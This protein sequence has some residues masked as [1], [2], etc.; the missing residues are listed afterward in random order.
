MQRGLSVRA[1]GVDDVRIRIHEFLQ[2]FQH[3]QARRRVC[4][5]NGA[6]LHQ[7]C[8]QFGCAVV[9]YADATGP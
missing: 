6:P 4:I 7:E 8:G 1:A 2:L 3:A 9:Q 5:H